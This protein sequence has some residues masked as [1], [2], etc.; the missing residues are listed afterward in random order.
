[1]KPCK[2]TKKSTC[3]IGCLKDNSQLRAVRGDGISNWE[4]KRLIKATNGFIMLL[5]AEREALENISVFGTKE[6]NSQ[7]YFKVDEGI[8]GSV[9][10][11]GKGELLIMLV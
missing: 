5:N 2:S 1:M 3:S 7:T 11:T 8:A 4:I 10:K 9:F 6:L